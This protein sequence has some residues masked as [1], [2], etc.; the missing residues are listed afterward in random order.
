[1]GKPDIVAVLALEWS[2]F[3]GTL[4]L[5]PLAGREMLVTPPSRVL[6]FAELED[7]RRSWHDLRHAANTA[8]HSQRLITSQWTLRDLLSHVASWAREFREEAEVSLAD[9]AFDYEIYFEPRV[10]PTEWNHARVAER[11]KQSLNDIFEE[12][13][14]EAR[15]LQDIVLRASREQLYRSAVFPLVV[16]AE[17]QPLVRSLA[18]LAGARCFH[19][20][21]HLLRIE[22]AFA[23]LA[24]HA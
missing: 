18:E 7:V 13:D 19:D 9:G 17:R 22:A 6:L 20:R 15:G 4:Q 2:A 5:A 12:L 14:A 24:L 10:G 21:H 8:D 11:R 23:R 3:T 16:G 1:M